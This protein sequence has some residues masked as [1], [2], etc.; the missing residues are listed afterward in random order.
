M[1]F[2]VKKI[3]FIGTQELRKPFFKKAQEEGIIEFIDPRIV[4]TKEIPEDIQAV[5]H[6]IKILRALPLVSQEETVDYENADQIS[7]LIL[8]TKHQID[9]LQEEE[10]ILKLE[11]ARIEIFGNFSIEDLNFIEREGKRKI[12]FFCAKKDAIN[13]ENIPECVLYVDSDHGLDYFV[14]VAKEKKI[15]DSMIE[16]KIEKPLD[17]LL[18]RKKKVVQEI[19]KFSHIL[20]EYEKYN[21]YLHKALIYKLNRYHLINAQGFVESPLT[22]SL[23]AVTAWVPVN[24]ISHL[25]KITDQY[26]VHYEE[27]AVES[28]DIMPTYLENKG[29]A[30]IGEDLVHIYDTPAPTDRDPSLWVL[31]SFALFFSFIVGDAGYGLILLL[32]AIYIRYRLQPKKKSHI[33]FSNLT[34]ILFTCC[35]IWGLLTTSFFGLSFPPDSP[36]RKVSLLTFLVEKKTDYHWKEKDSTYQYWIKEHPETAMLT[37][38]K[39]ILLKA[40]PDNGKSYPMLEKFSLGVMAELALFIGCVHV[41]ISLLRYIDRNWVSLGWVLFIIGA[42]FYIPFYLD[43]PSMMNYIFGFDQENLAINGIYL[44]AGGMGL[45]MILSLFI[46]KLLGIF[47]A[48]TVVQVPL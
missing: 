41:I 46:N 1:R 11:I 13:E 30:R 22:G 31:A 20:K 36:L 44:M 40:T 38:P 45:A 9:K 15:Y 34:I 7:Q 28:K 3:L 18:A 6:A 42:Y 8:D 35:V 26:K 19:E 17:E 10:R 48:M 4:K 23:F 37:N 33:R 29:A 24:K 14:S 21:R 16:M 5:T 25:D 27:I 12:Q 32:V 2:D 39:A 43:A 47:E